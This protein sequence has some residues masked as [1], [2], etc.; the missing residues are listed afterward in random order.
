MIDQQSLKTFDEIYYETYQIVLKYIICNCSNIE[1]VKDIIQNT[2]LDLY[3]K[4]IDNTQIN[5]IKSY[6]LTIAKNKLKDYYRFN[7][8]QKFISLFSKQ[9]NIELTDKIPSEE[10]IEKEIIKCEDIDRIWKYLS[11]KKAIISKIFYLYYYLDL[12]I[13]EISKELNITE[14]NVKHYLYRTLKEL[15]TYLGGNKNE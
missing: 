2:Y 12:S 14:S 10:D 11:K 8:K 7:Y 9:D 1:D 13:K 4:I 5:N 6:T 15:N 3:K